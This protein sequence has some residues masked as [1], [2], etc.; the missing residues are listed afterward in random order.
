MMWILKYSLKMVNAFL[1]VERIRSI[2]FMPYIM[3]DYTASRLTIL[4]TMLA[5]LHYFHTNSLSDNQ[6]TKYFKS[7][8]HF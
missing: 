7:S 1:S 8:W 6:L 4:L 3:S 2:T 5:V